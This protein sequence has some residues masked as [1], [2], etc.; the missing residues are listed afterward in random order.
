MG[1]KKKWKQATRGIS[2]AFHDV[3]KT[4]SEGV[5]DINADYY[6]GVGKGVDYAVPEKTKDFVNEN[7]GGILPV[8]PIPAILPN[9]PG[10]PEEA[11]PVVPTMAGAESKAMEKVNFKRRAMNRSKSIFTS[12]L[13]LS[14]MANT[15]KRYLTGQ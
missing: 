5:V 7:L 11:P 4:V 6:G 3:A 2:D 9:E 10:A 1:F 14:G 12:P 15:V 13:G 8:G